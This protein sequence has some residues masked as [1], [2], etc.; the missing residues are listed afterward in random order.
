[1]LVTGVGAAPGLDLARSIQRAG[2]RVIV[3]DSDPLA[4]GLHLP[5]ATP[6]VLARASAPAFPAVLLDLCRRW[7]PDAM[8][9]TVEEELPRLRG[10]RRTLL[11]R[12]VRTWLPPARAM[13]AALD[14]GAFAAVL[15]AH[16]I[17]APRSW[18]PDRLE[19]VPEGTPLIVKPRRGHGSQGVHTCE[20][21]AQARVLCELTP[22]PLV[23]ERVTGQ[24]FTADCL[25]D[26][27]GRASV[28]LRDRERVKGGLAVVS[29]TFTD[30][31]AE[32]VVKEVLAATGAAGLCCVQGFLRDDDPRVVITEM[33]ARVAGGFAVA[34]AAGAELVLQL[35]NGLFGRPVEHARLAYHPGVRLTKAVTTLAVTTT[36]TTAITGP[37]PTTPTT[38]T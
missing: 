28:I 23:Q 15:A 10:L 8:V 7:R 18:P 21:V 30:P 6:T 14:K 16:R 24:E 11:A 13:T 5:F 27:G 31:A 19:R 9:S 34:E 22:D 36:G 2:H 26:R 20:D 29:R 32:S 4:P 3:A 17:P 1:M 33:N 12:G 37:A 38:A 25:V 35:L